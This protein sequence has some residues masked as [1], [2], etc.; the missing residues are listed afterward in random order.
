MNEELNYTIR[1][2]RAVQY[3][4]SLMRFHNKGRS[5]CAFLYILEGDYYYK[6]AEGK[7]EA[8]RGD[9]VYLPIHSEYS[10]EI[11][12]ERVECIY[13]E[14][15]LEAE[16]E[17]RRHIEPICTAPVVF[18]RGGE[19][20]ALQALFSEILAHFRTEHF[21]AL[22]DLHWLI[23]LLLREA[24]PEN[25]THL[26]KIAPAVNYI[27]ENYTQRIYGAHLAELCGISEGHMRRLFAE[28]LGNSPI[29]YKNALAAQAACTLLRL[30]GMNVS[31]VAA[32]LRYPDVYT[33]SQAF[34]KEIG[35]SPKKYAESR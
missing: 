20:P 35:V 18:G 14:F 6:T 16:F 12:S 32:A 27:R 7:K 31:E 17:G 11:K 22:A 9:T 19:K 4:P 33:F 1:D 2:I 34:K 21:I 23:S 13:V 8:H 10:Y 30:D 3:V 26:G 5:T 24:R 15:I 25:N 29:G 28:K